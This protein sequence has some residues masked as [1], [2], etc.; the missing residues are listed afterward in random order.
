MRHKRKRE[1]SVVTPQLLLTIQ[2]TDLWPT[3]AHQHIQEGSS[4]HHTA[5][6]SEKR[7]NRS[8]LQMFHSTNVLW[9]ISFAFDLAEKSDSILDLNLLGLRTFYNESFLLLRMLLKCS[10]STYQVK[11]RTLQPP[12]IEYL[13]ST[14]IT[15]KDILQKQ[16]HVSP[17]T[18]NLGHWTFV[19]Q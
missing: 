13:F 8:F 12:V 2:K 15:D 1:S 7:E 9:V 10:K 14:K 16:A 18:T 17:Q 19:P 6:Q 4:G 3:Q 5:I 11:D